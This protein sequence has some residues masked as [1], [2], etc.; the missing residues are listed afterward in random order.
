MWYK[1]LKDSSDDEHFYCRNLSDE[2]YKKTFYCAIK[3]GSEYKM[4]IKRS[5]SAFPPLKW[6]FPFSSF[7]F[8]PLLYF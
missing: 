5:E 4:I 8:F 3:P 2:N 1:A 6:N 7:H